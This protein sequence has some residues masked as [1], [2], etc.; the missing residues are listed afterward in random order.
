MANN[1][2]M[3]QQDLGLNF[4]K[5]RTRKE[6]LLDEMALVMPWAELVALISQ[7]APEAKAPYVAVS[8][9]GYPPVPVC[10]AATLAFACAFF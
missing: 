6:V 3:K 7:H 4:S 10:A 8:A 5:R 1:T 9:S 2:S